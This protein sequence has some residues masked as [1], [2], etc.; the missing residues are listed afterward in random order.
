M[1]TGT[2]GLL[3]TYQ[4]NKGNESSHRLKK[5]TEELSSVA[6]LAKKP[7]PQQSSLADWTATEET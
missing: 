6:G 1:E 4:T 5:L 2:G 3:R 7:S